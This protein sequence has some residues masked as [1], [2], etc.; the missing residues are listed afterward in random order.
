LSLGFRDEGLRFAA[1]SLGFGVQI[2]RIGNRSLD[3][4]LWVRDLKQ[5]ISGLQFRAYSLPCWVQR[6]RD[7]GFF[8]FGGKSLGFNIRG[9]NLE[10]NC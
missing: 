5:G 3:L 7:F 6:S 10:I 9:P 2:V 1:C 4:I 8:W